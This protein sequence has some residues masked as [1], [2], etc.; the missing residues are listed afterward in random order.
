M[1]MRS[2]DTNICEKSLGVCLKGLRVWFSYGK[3]EDPLHISSL[4]I[5]VN[6]SLSCILKK[7]KSK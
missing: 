3:F 4:D 2:L 6:N 1:G 7:S 5:D